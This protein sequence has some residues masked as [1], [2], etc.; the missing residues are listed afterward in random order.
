MDD[1]VSGRRHLDPLDVAVH[2]LVAMDPPT[3]T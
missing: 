3:A 2:R 1:V